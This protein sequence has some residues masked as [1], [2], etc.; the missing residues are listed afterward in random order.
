MSKNLS[1]IWP[2]LL[3]LSAAFVLRIIHLEKLFYFT[4]DEEVFALIGRRLIL[5]HHVPLIGGVTPFGFHVAPYFYWF[6]T[7][8]LAF[9][10]LNP[11]AWGYASA[12]IA[13]LTTF[14][15]YKVATTFENKKTGITA[16]AFWAFSYMANLYDRH[17]WGL[18]FGPLFSLIVI[19]CLFQII[20]GRQK[21]VYLLGLTLALII[22]ADLSYYT[23]LGLTILSWVI[24]KLP[25]KKSTFIAL[26]FIVLSFM[27]LVFFDARHN[28]AN[29]R[30]AV[31]FFNASRN[32]P[33]LEFQKFTDNLLIFPKSAIRFIYP[34]GDN[35][36]PKQYSY[37]RN[38]I[39]EKY[40]AIPIVWV[41]I[42][43]L[44]LVYFMF[45]SWKNSKNP[46]W[47]L[48]AL[49]LVVY[50][51]GIQLYGTVFNAET[52]EH[53]L[54]GVFAIYIMVT[55]LLI[56]RLPKKLWLIV[57]GFFVAVNLY[58]FSLAQNN[59]SLQNKRQAIEYT[60]KEVGNEEFSLE[61]I[62][63]CWRLNGYRY[64]FAVFGREPT[65]SFVD[66]NLGY[67]YGT[68]PISKD[69]PATVVAFVMHDY[70]P[71]QNS[72]YQ[73]YALYKSH[74][75][76]SSIFGNLEVII[77]DNSTGWFDKP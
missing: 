43:T 41:I 18:T 54:S 34:P 9:G 25:I 3:I 56:G 5:W 64:L 14:A 51:I 16:A 52:F 75:K 76:T 77:M 71:E 21:F 74:E 48:A 8:V 61:S 31:K 36:I 73:K 60:M 63:T 55:A 6:F 53:Y 23:F 59:Q 24:F 44:G 37:C 70:V 11:I 39:I 47:R 72:F 66:P 49:L 65:K 12:I 68:T 28:F 62:S 67:L 27:P 32:R 2:L 4:Y 33:G 22:H 15:I 19:Y 35:E 10:K 13:V 26:S 38:F 42:A 50:F 57:I 46:G 20:N 58:K 7:L 45:W 69:H 40:K 1:R 17:F 30:P 29:T